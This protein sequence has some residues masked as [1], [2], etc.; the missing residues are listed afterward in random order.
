MAAVLLHAVLTCFNRREQTLQ[1]LD[2]L[3]ASAAQAGVSLRATLVDDGST[4]GTAESVRHRHHWVELV[5]GT[6]DLFWNR[7]MNLAFAV[8]LDR[9]GDVFLWLNDDTFL[10]RDAVLRLLQTQDLVRSRSQ[11]E[12]LIV[13]STR[14][15]STGEHTY[16]GWLAEGRLRRFSY[17]RVWS[18]DAALP[19]DVMNGNCV[20]IPRKV[21]ASVGN[22]DPVFEHAMGDTDY[23]LR[24]RRA[25]FAIHV[26]PGWVGTCSVNAT[27]GS[28][29][30]SQLDLR[31]RWRKMMHRK[32]LPPR[33]W[34]HFTRRHGG[35]IWPA[36]FA[37]PY[38][39][40]FLSALTTG[41]RA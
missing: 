28:F 4:D 8:A 14:D 2:C 7:G 18:A 41:N 17:R 10:H 16:G 34:L 36:Y 20:L 33:S 37:W 26:A 6:G 27:Q 13:G 29:L 31:T 23:A 5:Q 15:A 11:A 1:C 30:D 35:A 25:G 32:G 21:A 40:L 24:S 9:P 39:R 38:A 3:E 12:A 19:C 22:L